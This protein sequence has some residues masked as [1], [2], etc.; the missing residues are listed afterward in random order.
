MT[1]DLA[2]KMK[3]IN[4]PEEFSPVESEKLEE[5]LKLRDLSIATGS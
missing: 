2:L 5:F 3:S 1:K 4:Q